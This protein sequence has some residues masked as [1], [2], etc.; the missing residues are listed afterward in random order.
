[1]SYADRQ[2]NADQEWRMAREEAKAVPCPQCHA[3][4]GVRCVNAITGEDPRF[5]AHPQR[6]TAA[7]QQDAQD[8]VGG[9]EG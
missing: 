1:M 2:R 3:P 9:G 7:A 5:P 4:R 8:T 6:I